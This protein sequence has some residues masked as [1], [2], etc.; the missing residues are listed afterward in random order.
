[1]V[2]EYKDTTTLLS[3]KGKLTE[4]V[5]NSSQNF[6]GIAIRHFVPDLKCGIISAQKENPDP[7]GANIEEIKSVEKQYIKPILQFQSGSMISSNQ[8][9][10]SYHLTTYYQ[11]VS[12]DVRKIQTS[13]YIVLIG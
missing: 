10:L 4:K 1:M 3:G 8:I 11:N 13:H 12:M 6:Y 5:I 2:K 9:L 7:V